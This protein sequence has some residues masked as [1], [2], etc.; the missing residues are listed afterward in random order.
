[1]TTREGLTREMR[2][3]EAVVNSDGSITWFERKWNYWPLVVFER[4]CKRGRAALAS[5]KGGE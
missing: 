2:D 1:M 5:L 4:P 3:I